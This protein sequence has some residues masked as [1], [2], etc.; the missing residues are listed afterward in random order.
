MNLGTVK[1]NIREFLSGEVIRG[2]TREKHYFFVK[3]E[4][5]KAVQTF[6]KE[7]LLE[8]Y[9]H[10]KEFNSYIDLCFGS[11]NLSVH[12]L[13]V[14]D[15]FEED[16]AKIKEG[17]TVIFNDKNDFAYF[18]LEEQVEGIKF[19]RYDVFTAN[20]L[21]SIS[22]EAERSI[23]PLTLIITFL[24]K[25][26][27]IINSVRDSIEGSLEVKNE[28]YKLKERSIK[29]VVKEYEILLKLLGEDVSYST[30]KEKNEYLINFFLRKN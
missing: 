6:I 18:K 23:N 22:K 9:P 3:P 2:I 27:D 14:L 5:A 20:F 19:T 11:G 15:F 7:K 16:T 4:T 8:N 10:I 28:T 17:K 29:A 1:A 26:E 13:E 12:I 30:I 24:E 21:K 25:K